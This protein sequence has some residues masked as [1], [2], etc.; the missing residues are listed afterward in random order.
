MV[1]GEAGWLREGRPYTYQTANGAR[2]EVSSRYRVDGRTVRFEVSAYNP[3]ATLIIDPTLAW[4]TYFG[5]D[6]GQAVCTDPAGKVY[7]AGYQGSI[8]VDN[9]P[10]AGTTFTVTLRL[11]ACAPAP[12]NCQ[13]LT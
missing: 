4:A 2:T 12:T 9:R 5:R 7:M 1:E 8:T 3:N 10:G 6:S 11:N 13:F